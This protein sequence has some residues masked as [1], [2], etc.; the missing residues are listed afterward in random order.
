MNQGR[1]LLGALAQFRKEFNKDPS[2]M[3]VWLGAGLRNVRADLSLDELLSLAFTATAIPAKHV[4][5]LVVPGTTGTQGD[6]S[7]V[8]I[9][10]EAQ[11]LYDDMRRDGLIR[12][13]AR[14]TP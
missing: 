12:T 11:G 2:R 9:S 10:A 13:K 8:Y 14:E 6:I 5:N 4:T 3:L 7:V 1:L